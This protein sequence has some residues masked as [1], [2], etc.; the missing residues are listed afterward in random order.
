VAARADIHLDSGTDQRLSLFSLRYVVVEGGV[1]VDVEHEG[2][3]GDEMA[4]RYGRGWRT[5]LAK[6]ER[7]AI[8][9]AKAGE[10]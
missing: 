6:P 4:E 2:L 1:R 10:E 3:P 7:V 5:I 9:K 8:G